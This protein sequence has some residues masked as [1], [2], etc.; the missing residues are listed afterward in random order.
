[1]NVY[2]NN[3]SKY[4]STIESLD[5]K[6]SDLSLLRLIVFLGSAIIIVILAN[7]RLLLPLLVVASVSIIAFILMV[8]SHYETKH[9]RKHASYL[10]EVNEH[11]ILRLEN[12]LSGFPSGEMFIDRDH[13]YASDLDIFGTHSL[14][15][16]LNRTT[17]NPG[18]A[19]INTCSLLF[20]C[21]YSQRGLLLILLSVLC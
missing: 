14:F 2:Q 17:T 6:L 11:E 15:Q 20:H 19:L 7:E 4:K 10:K 16:L 18:R 12:K 13:S 1:M 8:K 5:K 21:R 3:I 9:L